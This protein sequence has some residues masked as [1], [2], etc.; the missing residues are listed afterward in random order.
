VVPVIECEHETHRVIVLSPDGKDILLVPD[1]DR[2]ALLSV[3][4]PRWQR[5]AENLT[6]A[7]K[8]GW[9]EEIACLFKLD[10]LPETHGSG[11]HY[12]IA[13]HWG[14]VGVPKILT[15]WVPVATLSEDSLTDVTDHSA[16]RQAAVRCGTD[17]EASPVGPF[18]TLGWFEELRGWVEEIVGPLGFRLKGSFRQLNASPAFS[19]IRFETDGP[20]L[21]F[22][23]VGEPNHREFPI[24]CELSRMLPRYVPIV[25]G[26][27]PEWNGWLTREA[28]GKLLSEALDNDLWEKSASSLAELQIDSIDHGT[29]ILASGARDLGVNT[30]SKMVGPFIET[31]T[32]LMERQIKTPP[33][34]LNR[35]ELLL[36]GERLHTALE[37]LGALELPETLGHLDLNPGNIVASPD[38]CVFLD[39]AEAYVGNPFLTFQYLLEH[40]RRTATGDYAVE[41]GLVASYRE[42]WERMVART[43]IDD[44]LSLT[45][46]LAV[47][48]CAAGSEVWRDEERMQ[49][50]ATAAYL[51]SLTRRMHR[52]ANSLCERRSLCLR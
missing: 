37:A 10:D 52:E 7:V 36:L 22:K 48:A 39:W 12:Q 34:P 32:Q 2:F 14:R 3:E 6:E 17:G 5:V 33:A 47:F 15:K 16:I 43:V 42:R 9:G 1:G 51:R 49:D 19:L 8:S 45:P 11:V 27:R 13:R 40:L 46:L 4:I 23:A 28:V 24:T 26:T 18:T 21:W 30:L 31:M 29:Q 50:P 41:V 35:K 20:A 25:L 44:A 38:H